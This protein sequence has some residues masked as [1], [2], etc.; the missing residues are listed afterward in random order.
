MYIYNE[1]EKMPKDK[2]I[3][4]ETDKIT[5]K[6]R[7]KKL[8]QYMDKNVLCDNKFICSHYRECKISHTEKSPTHKFY[9]GQLNHIGK[10]YDLIFN[11]KELRIMIVSQEF[12]HGDKC[13]TLGTRYEWFKEDWD[14]PEDSKKYNRHLRGTASALR[15]LFGKSLGVDFKSEWL[16][17]DNGEQCHIFDAFALVNYLLCS[18]IKEKDNKKE[19]NRGYST[20]EMK[21]NCLEHFR[22]TLEILQ[23][24]VIIVQG[25]VIWNWIKRSFDD[26][27]PFQKSKIIYQVDINNNEAY[28][29]SFTHPSA[30]NSLYNWGWVGAGYL[31]KTVKPTI[32]KIQEI[33]GYI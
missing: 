17:F 9:E 31:L 24:N 3:K 29:A 30:P 19:S 25:K 5:T 7:F 22:K 13:F 14:K 23:P 6:K 8:E 16:K 21:D 26:I 15:L 27:K 2:N 11:N 32:K 10:N 20:R 28:V 33:M 4:I 18:A 12:G 1:V